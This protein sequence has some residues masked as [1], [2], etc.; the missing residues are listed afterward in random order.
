[1][2]KTVFAAIIL[3]LL[4]AHPCFANDWES[5]RQ[6]RKLES[7]MLWAYV[8][9]DFSTLGQIYADDFTYID[10]SGELM[11]KSKVV[12]MVRMA[13]FRVDSIPVSNSRVRVYGNTAVISGVRRFYRAGKMLDEVRYTEVWVN[14]N[15]RWQCVSGQLTPIVE[16]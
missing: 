2:Y 14:R 3:L 7:E 9:L 11:N 16:K 13:S 12:N 1:M 15:R 10:N 8:M 4:H 6:L 5:E